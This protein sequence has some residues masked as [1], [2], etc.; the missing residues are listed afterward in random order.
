[1]SGFKEGGKTGGISMRN[2]KFQADL[3]PTDNFALNSLMEMLEVRSKADFLAK[4]IYFFQMAVA[5]RK[6][7]NRIAFLSPD[8]TRKQIVLMPELER[9]APKI[10]YSAITLEW[11]PEEMETFRKQSSEP[12]PEPTEHLVRAMKTKQK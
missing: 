4:A 9:V 1:L 7:G 3:A 6:L 2:V 12:Q 8:G 10:D 11:T 5:E